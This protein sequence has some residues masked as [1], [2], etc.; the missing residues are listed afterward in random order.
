[1]NTISPAPAQIKRLPPG[2]RAVG[3][4]IGVLGGGLFNL[5][6]GYSVFQFYSRNTHFVPYDTSDADLTS[7]IHKSHNPASNPPVAIDHAVRVV[8]LDKLKVRDQAKLTTEFCRGIWSG[9]GYAY[10]RRYLEKKYKALPGREKQLWSREEL[11]TSAYEVGTQ[12]TDHFE[13]LEHSADKVC[14]HCYALENVD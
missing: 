11:G 6:T 4:F 12:I 1:M 9:M 5:A 2:K 7:A 3:I 8:P 14:V 10:Q 13:V